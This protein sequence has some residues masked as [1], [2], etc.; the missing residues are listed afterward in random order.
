MNELH[1][2]LALFASIE[3]G[4]SFWSHEIT[5]R[6]AVDVYARLKTGDMTV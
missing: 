4:T 1:A 6:G 2:R 5:A 3:A